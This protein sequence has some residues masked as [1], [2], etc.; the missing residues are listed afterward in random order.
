MS[1]FEFRL[2][3]PSDP[4]FRSKRY[5]VY[6]GNPHRFIGEVIQFWPDV[7]AIKPKWIA[8]W[9]S[10]ILLGWYANFRTREQAATA[11]LVEP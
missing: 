9:P 7:D 8:Q 3:G 11:L 10:G 1:A 5:A 4:S 2:Q 6:G